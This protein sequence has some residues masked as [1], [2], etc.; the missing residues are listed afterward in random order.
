MKKI[1]LTITMAVCLTFAY[2][3]ALIPRGE[4]TKVVNALD[5]ST[6]S[7]TDTT[8]Y[9]RFPVQLSPDWSTLISYASVVGSGT[10]AVVVSY[11]GTTWTAYNSSPSATAT[12]TGTYAF[13]DDRFVWMYIGFKITKST[14]S[15]GTLTCSVFYK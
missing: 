6:I 8:I 9:A 1:I 15:A 3:Q 14:I 13:E 10:V 5:L 4:A 11:D 7:G 12:G 2:S